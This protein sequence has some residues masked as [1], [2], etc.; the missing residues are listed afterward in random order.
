MPLDIATPAGLFLEAA[1]RVEPSRDEVRRRADQ[2]LTSLAT[3]WGRIRRPQDDSTS[4]PDRV[5]STITD[6]LE[7]LPGIEPDDARS[8]HTYTHLVLWAD[9]PRASSY[10][11][12]RLDLIAERGLDGMARVLAELAALA[13]LQ[14]VAEDVDATL[15]LRLGWSDGHPTHREVYEA[16]A[17]RAEQL[18]QTETFERLALTVRADVA[19]MWAACLDQVADRTTSFTKREYLAELARAETAGSPNWALNLHA[20]MACF[21]QREAAT[22]TAGSGGGDGSAG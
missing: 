3:H 8:W 7:E 14:V 13:C 21:A 6:M 1:E 10:A 5:T 20:R 18:S 2:L 11:A 16:V 12:V 22:Q 9:P 4:F 19:W 17:A 15:H